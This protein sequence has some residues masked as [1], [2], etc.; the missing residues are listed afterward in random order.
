ML[1][2]RL[3]HALGRV[4]LGRGMPGLLLARRLCRQPRQRHP[5]TQPRASIGR[6]RELRS[7]GG[8]REERDT[9][10]PSGAPRRGT[11]RAVDGATQAGRTLS[12]D[13]TPA[14]PPTDIFRWRST[15]IFRW[16]LTAREASPFSCS[17]TSSEEE[18]LIEDRG[19]GLRAEYGAS[20]R[21]RLGHRAAS[22]NGDRAAIASGTAEDDARGN[23]AVTGHPCPVTLP[24]ARMRKA[25]AAATRFP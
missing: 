22:R 8:V 9:G 24:R 19:R 13:P 2:L 6:S 16:R 4:A 7:I 17:N 18:S 10:R 3:P 25:G 11:A 1:L 12:R 23:V 14:T 15:D 5:R 21:A 20:V